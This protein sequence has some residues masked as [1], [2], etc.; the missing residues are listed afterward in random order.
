MP[1]FSFLKRTSLQILL[2]EM[3]LPGIEAP[4]ENLL[5]K[6]LGRLEKEKMIQNC[7]CTAQVWCDVVSFGTISV[8]YV[9]LVKQYIVYTCRVAVS[10]VTCLVCV[11]TPEVSVQI[12]T[13][14][15]YAA[16]FGVTSHDTQPAFW[17]PSRLQI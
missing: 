15:W 12:S 10:V 7:L 5:P 3:S 1:S 2:S 17:N 8:R 14:P 13:A 9:Q 11:C 4:I 16:K 6:V